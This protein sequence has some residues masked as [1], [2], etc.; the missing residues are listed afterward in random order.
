ENYRSRLEFELAEYRGFDGQGQKFTQSWE[1]V[2]KEFRTDKD[3]GGQLR[4]RNYFERNVPLDLISGE[5][6]ALAKARGI[7][8]FVKAHYSWNGKFG[9]FRDN[10][11][12]QAFD[13]KTGNVAEIN[14]TLINLLNAAGIETDLM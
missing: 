12:K 8:Q 10:R 5:G 9:I 1:D 13:A 14:I 11:V 7:H 4:K 2:D 6:D 3:I